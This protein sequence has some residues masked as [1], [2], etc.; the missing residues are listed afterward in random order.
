MG[1]IAITNVQTSYTFLEPRLNGE[2][3]QNEQVRNRKKGMRRSFKITAVEK[4]SIIEDIIKYAH[5]HLVICKE[6]KWWR[7]TC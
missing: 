4:P 5:T 1:Q 2:D 7:S 6:I 3:I